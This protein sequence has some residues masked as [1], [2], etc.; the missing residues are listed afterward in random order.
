M[1]EPTASLHEHP[2]VFFDGVCVLCNGIVDRA[3][4]A[5]RAGT[6]RFA[7]LQGETARRLLTA[8]PADPE[9]WSMLYLDEHGLQVQSDALLAV[10]RR[11]GGWWRLLA[12]GALVPRAL[13]D[14]FYR[15]IA[16]NRYG[17]FGRH[18]VC[19]VPTEA[20]RARFLP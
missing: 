15:V 12:L 7:S 5:D 11:L 16:R 17:W 19:R 9:T 4:R 8:P 3:L 6:L 10:L 1:T 18:A 2:I 14:R 20:E 13:R